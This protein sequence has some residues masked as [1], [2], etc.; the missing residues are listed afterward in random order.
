MVVKRALDM[1]RVVALDDIAVTRFRSQETLFKLAREFSGRI[2]IRVLENSTDAS[3]KEISLAYL[4]SKRAKTIDE[5]REQAQALFVN[6]FRRLQ[7]DHPE[8]FKAFLQEGSR[9]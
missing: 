7:T 8:I 2:E 4:A 6:E 1:G 9:R 5:L 3:P